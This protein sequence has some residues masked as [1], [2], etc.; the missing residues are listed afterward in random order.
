MKY[1]KT[2]EASTIA[3]QLTRKW[4]KERDD[5]IDKNIPTI[6]GRFYWKLK[7]INKS[8]L[9]A[10]L[11]KIKAPKK[12]VKEILSDIGDTPKRSYIE[13]WYNEEPFGDRYSW[14]RDKWGWSTWEPD[15]RLRGY[16]DRR[17]INGFKY[18][19]VVKLSK[20]EINLL[21]DV[22]KYNL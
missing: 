19:G 17:Y 8:I 12:L 3:Q 1:L 14:T 20:E 22:E 21:L 2:F 10:S 11:D 7:S 6:S 15:K 16:Y 4:K 13:V 18:M 9:K 5:G